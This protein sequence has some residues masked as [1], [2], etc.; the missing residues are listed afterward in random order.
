MQLRYPGNVSVFEALRDWAYCG[1]PDLS[2]C[3][4]LDFASSFGL[5]TSLGAPTLAAS[6]KSTGD[7]TSRPIFA[8]KYSVMLLYLQSQAVIS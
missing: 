2:E 1:A 7:D 3:G 4:Y 6:S 5:E 8:S